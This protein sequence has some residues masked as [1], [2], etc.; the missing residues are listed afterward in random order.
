MSRVDLVATLAERLLGRA[1]ESV[2]QGSQAAGLYVPDRKI[3]TR[4]DS[5]RKAVETAIEIVSLSEELA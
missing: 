5:P 1:Y 2:V 3:V 4:I